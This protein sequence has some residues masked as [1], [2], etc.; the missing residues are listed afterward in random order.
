MWRIGTDAEV[1]WIVN[2]TTMSGK[3]TAA[4]PPGFEAYAL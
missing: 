3:I 4:I 2:A 1:A